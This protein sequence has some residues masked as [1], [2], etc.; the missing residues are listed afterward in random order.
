MFDFATVRSCP[1][2]SVRPL[3][4]IACRRPV[5]HRCYRHGRGSKSRDLVMYSANSAY[6]EIDFSLRSMFRRK[7]IQQ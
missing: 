3:A 1:A 2:E 4:R 7:Y 6:R 5:W